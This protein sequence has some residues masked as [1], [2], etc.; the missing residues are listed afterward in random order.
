MASAV[1]AVRNTWST[2]FSK[3]VKSVC[4]AFGRF[5][6]LAQKRRI[7]KFARSSTVRTHRKA[8]C[9]RSNGCTSRSRSAQ[10]VERPTGTRVGAQVLL[11][12]AGGEAGVAGERD[13]RGIV[14]AELGTREVHGR[15][16]R[17]GRLRE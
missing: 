10:L 17:R 15:A 2:R 13:H 5:D 7:G 9:A 4:D 3:R 11:A 8:S 6:S 12:F 14:G 1:S 16:D